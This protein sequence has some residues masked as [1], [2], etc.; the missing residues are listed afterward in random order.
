M[1]SL[2]IIFLFINF[3]LLAQKDNMGIKSHNKTMK[4]LELVMKSKANEAKKCSILIRKQ[5]GDNQTKECAQSVA[6]SLPAYCKDM[7]SGLDEA[8]TDMKGSLSV[9]TDRK[10]VV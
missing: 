4:E 5:C 6:N 8:S 2:L 3:S 7:I 1:K 9:C 10:S